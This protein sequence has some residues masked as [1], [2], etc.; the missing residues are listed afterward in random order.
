MKRF[1]EQ[2][3][4]GQRRGASSLDTILVLGVILPLVLFLFTVVPRMIQLVYEMTVV[5]V[6]SPL[7]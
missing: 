2:R 5:L 7:L 3:R 1:Q 6:N 4:S